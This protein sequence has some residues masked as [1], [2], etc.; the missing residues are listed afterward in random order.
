MSA[1]TNTVAD[2]VMRRG[3]RINRRGFVFYYLKILHPPRPRIVVSQKID[4]RA[5]ARN[6]LRRQIREIIRQ[7]GP[8]NRAIAIITRKEILEMSFTEIKR[9]LTEIL[10]RI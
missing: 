1:T 3:I 8:K 7:V 5:T 4:K 6:R 10:T 2:R 9:T